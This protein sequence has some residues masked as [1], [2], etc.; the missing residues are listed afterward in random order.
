MVST[1]LSLA[2]ETIHLCKKEIITSL[3]NS[4]YQTT[5]RQE[6]LQSS[7]MQ[8]SLGCTRSLHRKVRLKKVEDGTSLCR[9]NGLGSKTKAQ[10]MHHVQKMKK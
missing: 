3:G 4:K 10:R 1:I 9:G 6:M 5:K 7:R 2:A 8:K